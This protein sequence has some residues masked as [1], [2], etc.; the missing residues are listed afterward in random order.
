[1]Q[2][3]REVQDN[4]NGSHFISYMDGGNISNLSGLFF[5]SAQESNSDLGRLIVEV[6]SILATNFTVSFPPAQH[7]KVF[8]EVSTLKFGWS[9]A[10]SVSLKP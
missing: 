4:V 5:P 8:L 3:V 9:L 10:I 2:V 1:M 6:S 7:F